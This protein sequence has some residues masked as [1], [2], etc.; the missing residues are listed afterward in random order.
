LPLA[1]IIIGELF[2]Y[3]QRARMQGLFS[4]V[5]GVSSIVG[6]LLGGFLVDQVSWQWVFLVNLLPGAFIGSLV[7]FL[8]PKGRRPRAVSVRVD[9]AGAV[10]LTAGVA[11]LLLALL[12]LGSA[13]SWGCLALAAALL[14]A[15]VWVERR[16]PDP[17]LPVRLLQDRLFAVACLHGLLAGWAMFGS[18]SYVP[19]FVQAVLG[20]SATVAGSTLTP[21]MLSWVLASVISSRLLLVMR[22]RPLVISGMGLLVAG[23]FLLAQAGVDSSQASLMLALGLMGSGMGLSIPVFLIVVQSTVPRRDLGAAT[24]TL[25]FSRSMGGTIGVSVMGA[26]LAVWLAHSLGAA[27]LS[28]DSV[29]LNS[30][31]DPA[32]ASGAADANLAIREALAAAMRNTFGLALAGA[33]LALGATVLSPGGNLAEAS[34]SAGTQTGD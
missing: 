13:L 25:Q 20:T 3:Q 9:Y 29:S 17:V 6:P 10:I 32:T 11:L 16:A 33:V 23:A 28:P 4:G 7:W 1:F 12:E 14:A 26:A 19:L 2:D 22:Y 31:L 27:G 34:A 8:L 5:W 15:L 24:S 30:L 18:L 21:L